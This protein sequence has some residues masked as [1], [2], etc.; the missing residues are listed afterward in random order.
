MLILVGFC[1]LNIE[2]GKLKACSSQLKI[3]ESELTETQQMFE[4]V[5]RK[6]KEV[7]V[8]KQTFEE[9]NTDLKTIVAKLE[10]NLMKKEKLLERKEESI[11]K[12]SASIENLRTVRLRFGRACRV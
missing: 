1:R 9:Q 11:N 4:E 2:R 10:E 12:A 6:L 7:S 5:N 8:A 3:K